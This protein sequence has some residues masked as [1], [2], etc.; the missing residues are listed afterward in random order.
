M[1]KHLRKLIGRPGEGSFSQVLTR[2]INV[3]QALAMLKIR[4][5]SSPS[6]QAL[7]GQARGFPSEYTRRDLLGGL[8]RKR[9]P[10]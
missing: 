9:K 2:Q 1:G 6:A 5:V 8:M 7:P 4:S 3:I 10:R